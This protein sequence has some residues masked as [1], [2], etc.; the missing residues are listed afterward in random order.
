MNSS[1]EINLKVKLKENHI[2]DIELN[3]SCT[4]IYFKRRIFCHCMLVG[5]VYNVYN[6]DRVF[7]SETK[8]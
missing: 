3:W 2:S 1:T 7:K 8:Q 5:V 4:R 6:N